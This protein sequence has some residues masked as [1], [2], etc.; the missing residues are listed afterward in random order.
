MY[1]WLSEA[2]CNIPNN[3]SH[4]VTISSSFLLL[5][6]QQQVGVGVAVMDDQDRILVVQVGTQAA[7]LAY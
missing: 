5:H 2:T 6:D 7:L 4:Y 3:A 1:T